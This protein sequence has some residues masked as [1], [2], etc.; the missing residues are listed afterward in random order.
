MKQCPMCREEVKD[1]ALKCRYC[2]TSFVSSPD[3]RTDTRTEPD[4]KQVVLVL[5]RGFLYF[6]KF[7]VGI[8]ALV[9]AFGTAYFGFDLNR[10]RESIEETRQK[11]AEDE[12]KAEE[13]EKRTESAQT[14]LQ[15]AGKK[16]ADAYQSAQEQLNQASQNLVEAKKA[17]QQI[18]QYEEQAQV[19]VAAILTPPALNPNGPPPVPSSEKNS[20]PAI[21]ELYH[22]PKGLDGTGQTIGIVELSGGFRDADIEKYF[23]MLQLRRPK[24]TAVSVDEVTTLSEIRTQMASWP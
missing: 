3:N 8:V 12:T 10:A 4:S 13:A 7:I 18:Q 15:E 5:D 2:G 16:A 11:V 23:G 9:F 22:F 6:A 1:D 24:V 19:Y 21:A 20:I 17:L 14:Q